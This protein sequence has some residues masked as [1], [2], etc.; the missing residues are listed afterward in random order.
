MREVFGV[1]MKFF[2]GATLYLSGLARRESDFN[3]LAEFFTKAK[4]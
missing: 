2:I 1:W 4:C 3:S